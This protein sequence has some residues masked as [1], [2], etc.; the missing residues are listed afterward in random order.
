[1]PLST[2]DVHRKLAAAID[3][4]LQVDVYLLD[5]NCSERSLTHQLAVH[6]A[7]QFPEYQVD[8]EYNRDGFDVKRLELSRRDAHV[9]DDALDAVTVF[10][11]VVVHERGSNENNLLVV[12]VKKAT[13]AANSSYDI[14]KLRAFKKQL[15]YA[16]AVH[17]I[18]G[19]RQGGS[20]VREQLWQ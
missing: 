20:V 4:L 3:D 1:M 12:E 9:A 13:S 7:G 8:C 14:K 11:D 18:I 5:A 2:E 10:P 6:L 17:L 16:H 19:N 15:N